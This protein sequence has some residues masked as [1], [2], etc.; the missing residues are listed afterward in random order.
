M[1]YNLTESCGDQIK[2]TAIFSKNSPWWTQRAINNVKLDTVY[3]LSTFG[4]AFW[5]KTSSIQKLCSWAEAE[6]G[7]F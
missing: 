4:E 6:L 7:H 3:V 1:F 2:T 5:P